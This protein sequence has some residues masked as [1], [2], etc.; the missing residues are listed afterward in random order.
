MLTKQFLYRP[1]FINYKSISSY[2]LQ[3][4]L[5]RSFVRIS[6]TAHDLLI[7]QHNTTQIMDI[8]PAKIHIRQNIFNSRRLAHPT[9]TTQIMDK[10]S[11][12]IH[13]HQQ[14]III[15]KVNQF[16]CCSLSDLYCFNTR[17]G[18]NCASTIHNIKT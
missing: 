1:I 9:N 8:L 12:K 14:T 4:N 16:Y 7:Q 11:A 15:R 5:I 3:D 6:R 2:F 17:S 10:L 13:I 18:H